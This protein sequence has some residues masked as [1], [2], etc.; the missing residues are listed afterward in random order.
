VVLKISRGSTVSAAKMR[1]LVAGI[2]LA[3]AAETLIRW[4]RHQ[5]AFSAQTFFAGICFIAAIANY[6]NRPTIT[7]AS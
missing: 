2:A 5:S 6:V 4:L 7:Y 1:M 3:V